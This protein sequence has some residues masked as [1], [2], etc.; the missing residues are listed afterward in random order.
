MS[1]QVVIGKRTIDFEVRESTRARR[2]RIEVTTGGVEVIVPRGT[3]ESD[4][5]AF[6]STRRRWL[7]DKTLEVREEIARLRARTPEGVHSGAKILFRDRYLRLRVERADVEAPELTYRTAFHVRV[8]RALSDKQRDEAV[9]KVVR[10][11]M[12]TRLLEDARAVIRHRGRPHGLEPRDVRVK[13][14]RTL[15]GSCGKDGVLRLDRKLAR[16]PKP[17][18]E[19]VVVHELCHLEH[20]DHSPAF[21]DLVKQ[22]RPGYEQEKAWLEAHEVGVG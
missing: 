20:R 21:W 12:D 6:V 17:V 4:L 11:W 10:G 8:P 5:M 3:T 7:H 16:V 9:E 13:D 18:F 22:M 14:Q 1:P 2:K 15:W 19:Y